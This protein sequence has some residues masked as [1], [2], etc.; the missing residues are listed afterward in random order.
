MAEASWGS[1]GD[2]PAEL[3]ALPS[4]AHM[5]AFL[6]ALHR[7]DPTHLDA[8]LAPLF[9]PLPGLKVEVKVVANGFPVWGD[10]YVRRFSL[11]DGSQVEDEQGRLVIL[12]NA[13]L[14]AGRSYGETS[15]AQ[16]AGAMNVLRH[17]VFHICYGTLR[18]RDPR[19]TQDSAL[20]PA[21]S[22]LLTTQNEGMGH[23]LADQAK[24]R[25]KGFPAERAER[26]LKDLEAALL[27]IRQGKAT[28]KLLL[29]ANQGPFWSKYAAISGMLF[30]YGVDRAQGAEGL[31]ASLR[32]GPAA[33]VRRYME[34]A[35]RLPELPKP[36]PEVVAWSKAL[37]GLR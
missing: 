31:K 22:L 5:E 6:Q 23:F 21:E 8:E 24:L 16:A 27:A 17:E 2:L 33:L 36:G 28:P 29:D 35:D 32:E 30:A 26:A 37:A 34:A 19:H 13:C 14:V 9:P 25:A 4:P 10:M 15:E 18:E 1:F 12:L 7:A 11:R 3:P 20:T